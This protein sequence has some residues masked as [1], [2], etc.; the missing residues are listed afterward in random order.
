MD[1][2]FSGSAVGKLPVIAGSS[3]EEKRVLNFLKTD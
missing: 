1:R 3:P 2:K